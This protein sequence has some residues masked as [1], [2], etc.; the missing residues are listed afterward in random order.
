MPAAPYTIERA[1]KDDRSFIE[2]AALDKVAWLPEDHSDGEHAWRLWTEHAVVFNA[3]GSGG[4]LHG[5]VLSFPCLPTGKDEKTVTMYC[6]H[7]VMVGKEYR[8]GGIGAALMEVCL[9]ETDRLGSDSFL[10][11]NP[12][13]QAATNLYISWG[14]EVTPESLVKGYYEEEASGDRL[15]IVRKK[16][17]QKVA[18]ARL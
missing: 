9:S 3:R 18:S 10:T 2:I 12:T 7:K 14:F 11:V 16:G 15:V 6:L 1:T 5:S 13:N 4:E 8:G 17:A